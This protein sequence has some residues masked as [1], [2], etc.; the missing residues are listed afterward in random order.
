MKTKIYFVSIVLLFVIRL[1]AQV[2]RSFTPRYN[3]VSVSGNILYISN[4]IITSVQADGVTPVST[5]ENPPGG[6]IAN[7]S[8]FG[9]NIDIDAD[10]ATFNSSSSNLTSSSYPACSHVLFAGLYWGAGQGT[11]SRSWITNETTCKL[12]LPGAS[13]Y[14]TITSE[15]TDYW[16]NTL[17]PGY[18]HA[19]FQC[20]KD[21][22]SLVASQV[23]AI[24]TYTVADVVSPAGLKDAYGGWTIVIVYHNS[25]LPPRN[26][27][28]YDG[29][30][31]V[32]SGMPAVDINITGFLTPP[33]GP[34][35]CELGAVVY[36]GD[37]V[38]T[39]SFAFKQNGAASFYNLTP[40]AT[41][42]FNDMWN[43]TVSYK[44]SVVTTRNPAF[45]NTLGYDADIIDLPNAGNA[46][47]SNSQTAA[48]VRMSSPGE[49][50]IAHVIT[51][52]IAQYDPSFK[53]DKTVSDIDGGS[54]VPGNHLRYLVNYN[55]NGN[56]ASTNSVITDN[57]PAGT[58]FDPGTIKINGV[59]KT[60]AAGDDEAEYDFINN[61]VVFRVGAG[62]DQSNGGTIATTDNGNV[63][64]DVITTSS[65][66]VISCMSTIKNSARI[67]YIGQL[68]SNALY[69]SSNADKSGCMIQ[70]PAMI[71]FAGSCYTPTDTILKNNCPALTVPLP[72]EKYAGYMFYSAMPFTAA[73]RI[74]PYAAVTSTQTYYAYFNSGTGCSDTIRMHVFI[75]SC[76]D[77]DDDNDGIP[78]Y[79]EINIPAALQDADSDGILNWNDADYSGYADVNSDGFN[80]NF[81]PSADSDN[82]GIPNFYD[83]DFPGYID[84]NNDGV[85]DNMD[86]DLDG[87]P[88][89]YDLDSDNDGIPDNTE[90]GGADTDGDGRID[91]YTDSDADGLS[92]N[93]DA[94]NTGVTSS[95]TGL[96]TPDGNTD[97]DLLPN[98]LDLDSDNDGLPDVVEVFGTDINNDGKIDNYTD[99]D[100]DGFSDSVDGD[101][102]ND[103]IA[104]NSAASLLLTGSDTNGDG[105]SDSY[106]FKNMDGDSKTNPYEL[107]S[108]GD[109]ITDVKEGFPTLDSNNDGRADGSFNSDGWNITVAAMNNLSLA[110][111]DGSGKVNVY[112]IDSDDDGIPDNIEGQA[113]AAYALPAGLDT[114]GDGIDDTYD[115]NVSFGGN[116]IPP[117]DTDGDG[118]PDY[119]DTDTDGD[120]ATDIDEGNDYN[121]N[122]MPDDGITLTGSDTDG[123]GLDDFFDLLPA[124]AKG[125]SAKMG[126]LG[127]FTGDAIPG[128]RATVQ[129][130][131]IAGC[132]NQRDWRCV[133]YVLK[134]DNISFK[135]VQQGEKVRLVW[136]AMC[137]LNADYFI[138]ERSIN[139]RTFNYL[140]KINAGGEIKE[141]TSFRL[142]DKLVVDDIPALYYRLKTV[143]ASKIYYS[144]T[145]TIPI[146][147]IDE[148]SVQITP[149]PVTDQ[150]NV[151]I[152]SLATKQIELSVF[153]NSGKAWI[154]T[155]AGVAAGPNLLS[156]PEIRI[157]PNGVYYLRVKLADGHIVI[158]KFE[159]IN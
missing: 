93:V 128:T 114:D 72:Y 42:I 78:D 74:N 141:H 56:D 148:E 144:A 94:S 60:D 12:K 63:Q 87:I 84:A 11:T 129:R 126:N 158:R 127:S 27:S 106:P 105:R 67:D 159:K 121:N 134:C 131:A 52:S 16:N 43:S 7:Q 83:T 46:N 98:Y 90:S 124:S 85:N 138:I 79:V 19:G 130:N 66:R 133:S 8:Y 143:T 77:I 100:G 3:N 54:L 15:Q 58:T 101:V 68:S 34:V 71:S 103:G 45:N 155:V 25:L 4:S 104:E 140:E 36:D 14:I 146:K 113:T 86:K 92:Q 88:N 81:D 145:I 75:N 35:S 32:K 21:I 5:N 109:G 30:A 41:S 31:A 70:G 37:R 120:G 73:N 13:S 82:D 20:F 2:L 147:D 157:C 9:S 150:L 59:P 18:A 44:G 23:N 152:L 139:G 38:F 64:F 108:D 50:Y 61:R 10:A 51:T 118:T 39:D 153:D 26:L 107:D 6:V 62:A 137:D 49:N 22:T 47:L 29:C 97:G 132:M 48:V 123:D 76:P 110:N 125:T 112:D 122:G 99:A 115:N 28:V 65:C 95:G 80:D 33:S 17:I 149:N 53:L 102:G 116:G 55:N 151:T 156:F 96:S 135:G 142:D 91:N 1:D 117:I 57:I 136:T 111:T 69:D 40:N 119:R 154:N 89:N 24:G